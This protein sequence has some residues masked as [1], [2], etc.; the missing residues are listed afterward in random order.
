MR[1]VW[2]V[3]AFVLATLLIGAGIAQRTVFLGPKAEQT[4]LSVTEPQR[5]TLIDGD[6]LRSHPG[7]QTVI[8]RG[9]GTVFLAQARTAD[10]EAWLAD[11][12]YNRVSIDEDGTIS[13][14][15]IPATI[16]PV[17]EDPAAEEPTDAAATDDAAEEQGRN[18]AGSDLW[19]T[20]FSDEGSLI[21]RMQI[22][23]GVSV[24]LASDGTED[25]PSDVI[26]SWPLENRTPFA[27]PLMVAGGIIMAAGL[28]LYVLAIRHSR[29]GR[30]PRR[31]GPPPLPPTEPIDV[32]RDHAELEEGASTK[33]GEGQTDTG[34]KTQ[35]NRARL[36]RR[37]ALLAVP[38]FAVT[39]AMLA[40]CTPDAWPQ[41]ASSPS[42]SPTATVVTPEDQQAPVMTEAQAARVLE[43]LS[44][45]VAEADETLD[46]ELAATRLMGSA[47]AERQTDYLVRASVPEYVAPS[48]I[49]SDK[50][51]IL[52]PQAFD[53][54]PR[55]TLMLAEAGSDETV[56]PVILTMT[57]DDPWSNYKI[58]YLAEMQA[59]AELPDLPPA[60]LGAKLTPPDS[61]F[62]VVAPDA[63]AEAF[64]SV[65]DEN[66]ASP[67]YELFDKGVHD[68]ATTIR[69]SR[70]AI[71]Q[72][73]ADANAATTS[74]MSFDLSPTGDVPMALASIDSGAIVAVSLKDSQ[75][76]VPTQEGVDIRVGNNAPAKALTGVESSSK[77]FVTTYGMQLF[78][79]VPA[80]GASAQVQLLAVS[81]EL[82]SVEVIP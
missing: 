35:Q 3:V 81:Q 13:S 2:A 70:A 74:A 78:F 41:Q 52:V 11:V 38:V 45:T 58:T 12:E 39:T 8:A 20:E 59:S 19:L 10:L 80:Q 68:F 15:V 62:L 69:D 66:E 57:Q 9:S 36:P 14:T 51:R 49:P 76:I 28:V 55:T 75:S 44:D 73:L 25:A 48:A 26:L 32:A 4:E 1:F 40:G 5:Y 31:K 50:I 63:L 64:A 22:P 82:L 37:R 65:V 43:N 7:E 77:G 23:E 53:G 17:E 6:V 27:G 16:L 72:A 33:T 18:P 30:G 56:P 71:V 67:A 60:W 34:A 54:W 47:L 21:E 24:L 29:R 61:P 79:S 46:A 42:P